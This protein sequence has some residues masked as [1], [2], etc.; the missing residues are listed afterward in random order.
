M[1]S[2]WKL[3]TLQLKSKFLY[4]NEMGIIG[5]LWLYLNE[6]TNFDVQHLR[7]TM[8]CCYANRF[9]LW[10]M[11]VGSSLLWSCKK[12]YTTACRFKL[13]NCVRIVLY[14]NCKQ[15]LL[16][17]FCQFYWRLHTRGWTCQLFSL[18]WP[19]LPRKT[20]SSYIILVAGCNALQKLKYQWTDNN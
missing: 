1:Y 11:L 4:K 2:T 19:F 16:T 8:R 5:P 6:L 14:S 7:C 18:Y 9:L 12:T 15:K 3:P 13:K 10:Y 17:A 20:R